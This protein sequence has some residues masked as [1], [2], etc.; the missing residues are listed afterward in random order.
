MKTRY[1]LRLVAT[2]SLAGAAIALAA[3]LAGGPRSRA[4]DD[5]P[6]APRLDGVDAPD[7]ELIVRLRPALAGA[8]PARP[9]AWARGGGVLLASRF[10]G[11]DELAIVETPGGVRRQLTFGGADVTAAASTQRT[12]HVLI[13]RAAEH[14]STITLRDLAG[15]DERVLATSRERAPTLLID[16]VHFAF[17]GTADGA[18]GI[19]VGSLV[20]PEELR[21]VLPDDGSRPVAFSSDGARLLIERV[22]ADGASAALHV[23]A[24]GTGEL[25]VVGGEAASAVPGSA[26]LTD[27]GAGVLFLATGE[28]G[29]LGPVL[30][31]VASGAARSVGPLLPA[32]RLRA[33]TASP[34]GAIAAIVEED[35]GERLH[36][37]DVRTGRRWRIAALP[38]GARIDAAIFAPTGDRLA[39]GLASPRTAGDVFVVVPGAEAGGAIVQAITSTETGGVPVRRLATP[40]IVRFPTFD[41]AADGERR[42]LA[43]TVH[44]PLG[45]STPR[46]VVIRFGSS[47]TALARRGYDPTRAYL[48][49]ELGVAVIEPELRGAGTPDQLLARV[50]DDGRR[51]EHV[52][53]DVGALLDWIAARPDLDAERVIV[54][55]ASYGGWLALASAAQHGE[56][57]RGAIAASPIIDLAA[58]AS[59][60]AAR[61]TELGDPSDPAV[62]AVLDRL[63]PAL[64]P[65]EIATPILI[66]H[67]AD[68]RDVPLAGIEAL[69]RAVRDAKRSAGLI[70][71]PG[72]GHGSLGD[73][74]R[75]ALA[76]AG[77]AF[78]DRLLE[79]GRGEPA[80][81]AG[82]PAP[83]KALPPAIAP[84]ARLGSR[85]LRHRRDVSA[86][87]F[88]PD[89]ER[90]ATGSVD[91]DVTIW[92][93]ATGAALLV[94]TGTPEGAVGAIAFDR[95]GG[96]V[97]VH[98]G[99]QVAL[100]DAGSGEAIARLTD[101]PKGYEVG[102]M[103][104]A[105]DGRAFGCAVTDGT[106][107]LFDAETG[108]PK[109]E[110]DARRLVPAIAFTPDGKRLVTGDSDGIIRIHDVDS[111]AAG[112]RIETGAP[113]VRL[114]VSRDGKRIVCAG[115]DGR[116]RLF[117]AASGASAGELEAKAGGGLAVTRD[118]TRVVA[119]D[120]ATTRIISAT[121][122]GPAPIELPGGRA[123]LS[124]DGLRVAIARGRTVRIVG[125][126]DGKII[127]DQPGHTERVGTVGW[128]PDGVSLT[129]GSDDGTVRLWKGTSA[130]GSSIPIGA[131]AAS[132]QW[133]PDGSFLAVGGDDGAVQILKPL[134]G[135]PARSIDTGV[136]QVFRIAVAPD[137]KRIAVAGALQEVRVLDVASGEQVAALKGRRTFFNAVAFSP[138]GRHVAAASHDG[139]ARLYELD[140]GTEV[141]RFE[142]H[143]G[144]V[145]GIAY[146]PDGKLL[147]TAGVDGKGIIHDVGTAAE[148][149]VLEGHDGPVNAIA[150][151]PDGAIVATAG[152]DGTVWIWAPKTG[153]AIARL[154]GADEAITDLVFHPDG[155]L[156]AAGSR[157]TTV[158]VWK[159]P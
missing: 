40:E 23:L 130:A 78:V 37:L 149:A 43:A 92:N 156:L 26:T 111:G 96:R 35:D 124:R 41:D 6:G 47:P 13:A 45:W 99:G 53:R 113:C 123:A 67:G 24:I 18:L 107:R 64:H 122:G 33:A 80:P 54:T 77:V 88:S 86:L 51:R 133:A 98:A 134:A 127:L 102:A 59:S 101:L 66:A 110:L 129:S 2:I 117:D 60:D 89:G 105:P 128:S 157:D 52:L 106:V 100:L 21:L 145:V 125:A 38:A 135:E 144:R 132:L 148:V 72:A 15:D 10:G 116:V 36:V 17:H 9:L 62:R 94:P 139:R 119:T 4:D 155:R 30:V 75:L 34:R 29:S 79:P 108:K 159:L 8:R 19:H 16:G 31:E 97:A 63:S 44:R 143:R 1:A 141:R 71:V 7:A 114:A 22:A 65:T 121:A 151:S 154:T 3:A 103:A 49:G 87:A 32:G 93:A 137:G 126:L 131:R 58:W 61:R 74:G 158:L 42:T 115:E 68:D 73:E 50:L 46:P 56:R 76:A 140:N 118:A 55:G 57:V 25:H 136:R 120:G 14:G 83:A 109:A 81:S 104:F 69:I 142:G 146:S 90:L 5:P 147:A 20:K 153:R 82:T 138:D 48:V 91:G 150:F 28:A 85:A 39:V 27:R 12:A 152:R 84:A 11:A 112:T 95:D 70:V